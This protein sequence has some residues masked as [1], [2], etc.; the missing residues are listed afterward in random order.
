MKTDGALTAPILFFER[1]YVVKKNI[2]FCIIAFLSA[3]LLAPGKASAEEKAMDDM[4]DM[5]GM[6]HMKHSESTS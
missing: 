1:N 3:S 2:I 6:E 5:P 4:K